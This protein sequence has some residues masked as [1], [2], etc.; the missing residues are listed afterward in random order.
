M[1]LLLRSTL[2]AGVLLL[3]V[4]AVS[5]LNPYTP[6]PHTSA[7]ATSFPAPTAQASDEPTAPGVEQIPAQPSCFTEAECS[8][9]TTVF[10][11][12]GPGGSCQ[13]GTESCS[14]AECSGTRG[15]VQCDSTKKVCPCDIG[16]CQP[17]QEPNGCT[18]GASC[19]TDTQCGAPCGTCEGGICVCL[20]IP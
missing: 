11:F 19:T 13:S 6:A 7:Q 4:L 12:A 18:P 3:L 15:F 14:V 8:N 16:S 20:R 1:K 9:G 17:C 2:A 5:G 10:C